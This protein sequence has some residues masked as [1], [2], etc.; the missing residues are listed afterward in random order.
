MNP[1]IQARYQIPVTIV[2][3]VCA[4]CLCTCP[5]TPYHRLLG[6]LVKWKGV[7]QSIIPLKKNLLKLLL[8]FEH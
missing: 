5:K 6:R 4:L 8:F 2:E 3:I 1:H 7:E